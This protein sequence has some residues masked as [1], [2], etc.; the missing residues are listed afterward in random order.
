MF[1]SAQI[2]GLVAI[3]LAVLAIAFILMRLDDAIGNSP[4]MD[5]GTAEAESPELAQ[6]AARPSHAV[7]GGK[8][9][10]RSQRKHRAR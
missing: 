6:V 4:E 8:K 5:A 10:S 7:A 2:V 1:S 9:L 3:T